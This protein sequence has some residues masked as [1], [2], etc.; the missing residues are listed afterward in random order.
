MPGHYSFT[1]AEPVTR[2]HL[3]PLEEESESEKKIIAQLESSLH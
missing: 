3:R 1:L 2:G